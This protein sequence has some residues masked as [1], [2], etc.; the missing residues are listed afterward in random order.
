LRK[1]DWDSFRVNFFVI[2]TPALLRESPVSYITS[3]Y[4]APTEVATLNALVREFPNLVMIDVAQIMSQVQKM[5]DQVSKAVQFVF[6]F[7]LAA[8]LA[9]LYAAI[10]S[11]GDE[12]MYEAA[13]MRT[14]GASRRQIAAVQFAEFALMGALAGLL[15]AGGASALGYALALKVLNV[16]YLGN[17]WVWPI[18]VAS[19][20]VGIA[21][22]GML[23][24]R[25]VLAVPPLQSLR[26]AS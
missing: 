4:V 9:V 14:L 15:A 1:V 20:A 17:P 18:G 13:I 10:A 11:T 5:M 23:G 21:I 22:A 3:F 24:T 8:G 16:P 19:G 25:R 26:R 2:T 7:T 12:R 6:L